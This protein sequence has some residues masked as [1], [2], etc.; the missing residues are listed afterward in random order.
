MGKK[1]KQKKIEQQKQLT[2]SQRKEKRRESEAGYVKPNPPTAAEKRNRKLIIIIAAIILAMIIAASVAIPVWFY[3]DYRNADNPIVEIKLDNGMTLKY[4]VFVSTSHNVSTNFLFL[5]NIGYFN[6]SIIY[7]TQENWVRFGGYYLDGE[8]E[9]AHRSTDGEFLA[10]TEKYFDEFKGE[11]QFKYK[12]KPD[13]SRPTSAD[14]SAVY[15]LFGNHTD[16]C[17]EF[18][19][20]GQ[21]GA[22]NTLQNVSTTKKY[23][24]NTEYIAMPYEDGKGQS[25]TENIAT[26]FSLGY[27]D[28]YYKNTF[29]TIDTPKFI[30]IVSTKVHNYNKPYTDNNFETYMISENAVNS[31]NWSGTYPAAA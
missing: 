24:Y 2:S 12:V 14:D 1:G 5:C 28:A 31:T 21:A 22:Q 20:L 11:K 16:Y 3:A 25:T 4:E 19:F 27:G 9:Y 15:G 18:Q 7:D 29:K 17:T 8:G 13:N 6:G 26:L 23:T 10:K 30:K